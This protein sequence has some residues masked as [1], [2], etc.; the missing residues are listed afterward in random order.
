LCGLTASLGS[1]AWLAGSGGV[2][3]CE[4]WDGCSS[5]EEW[6]GRGGGVPLVT[7]FWG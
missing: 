7:L 1:H 3:T 6:A 5:C 2:N 4:G